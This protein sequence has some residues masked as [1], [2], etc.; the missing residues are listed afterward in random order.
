[1]KAQSFGFTKHLLRRKR[2]LLDSELKAVWHAASELGVYGQ[3]VRTLMLT[4][5]RVS[6][7]AEASR[8][9]R[10]QPDLLIVSAHR[11]KNGNAHEIPLTPKVREILDGLPVYENSNWLFSITGN[12]PINNFTRR[13]AKLDALSGVSGYVLHDLRRTVRTRLGTLKVPREISERVIGHSLGEL[14]EVYDQGAYR[15]QKYEALEKW[16]GELLR[17]VGKPPKPTK[18]RLVPKADSAVAA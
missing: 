10:V 14:D 2:T 13:K 16:E 5:Q 12:R 9:E 4:G 1:M 7:F 17:I 11:Y 18:L 6:E 8:S 15:E 3:L